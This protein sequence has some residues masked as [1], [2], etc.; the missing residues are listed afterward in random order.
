MDDYGLVAP[1]DSIAEVLDAGLRSGISTPLWTRGHLWGALAAG[2][3]RP[4]AFDAA[5]ERRLA[6]FAELATIAVSNAET[7]AELDRLIDDRPAHRARQP[8]RVHRPPGR[9]GRA[10]APP[11]PHAGARDHGP[12]RLQ[13]DQRLARPPGG[14]RGAGGG[15][16]AADG[17]VPRAASWSR[18]SAARSSPGSCPRSTRRGRSR[19]WSGPGCTSPGSGSRA[20]SGITCSAGVCDL[21]VGAR[22]RGAAAPGGPGALQREAGGAGPG[23]LRLGARARLTSPRWRHDAHRSAGA[24]GARRGA[25]A[26]QDDEAPAGQDAAPAT[27]PSVAAAGADRRRGARVRAADRLRASA[28]RAR[29]SRRPGR[30]RTRTSAPG[31]RTTCCS[32]SAPTCRA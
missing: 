5:D 17:D 2:S 13:D 27:A 18:A 29:R 20:S 12:R 32:G 19:P 3:P 7:R 22:R 14:R 16:P 24:P 26:P 21:S 25:P 10:G 1:D 8:A 30:R 15:G 28:T 6:A 23:A 9:R 4:G 31:R 11:R